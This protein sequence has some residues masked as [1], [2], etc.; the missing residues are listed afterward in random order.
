[1]INLSGELETN[2]KKRLTIVYQYDQSIYLASNIIKLE[3]S[4]Q[5][6]FDS[7]IGIRY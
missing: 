3:K 1:M 4:Y 5:E 6:L 7:K 2:K